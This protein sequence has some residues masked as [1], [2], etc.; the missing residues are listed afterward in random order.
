[1]AG[2]RVVAV[3]RFGVADPA[4][5]GRLGRGSDVGGI[6]CNERPV[7]GTRHQTTTGG[8]KPHPL[9]TTT[10]P[11]VSLAYLAPLLLLTTPRRARGGRRGG[12][13][14]GLAQLESEK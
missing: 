5:G 3:S 6:Y 9:A 2:A 1:M 8:E 13:V 12:E 10:P 4:A 11:Y 7:A 14:E